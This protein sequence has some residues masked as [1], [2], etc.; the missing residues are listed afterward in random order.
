MIGLSLFPYVNDKTL[1]VRGVAS[2]SSF[3]SLAPGSSEFNKK[4][5]KRHLYLNYVYGKQVLKGQ[6]Y[7]VRAILWK[8]HGLFYLE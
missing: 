1:C 7:F 6:K 2:T 3:Y 4:N 5:V 8:M